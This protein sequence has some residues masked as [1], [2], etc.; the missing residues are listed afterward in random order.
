MD[1]YSVNVLNILK[2]IV[3]LKQRKFDR[4]AQL[5]ID[6]DPRDEPIEDATDELLNARLD[7]ALEERE[8]AMRKAQ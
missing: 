5:K 7:V 4:L 8:I 3:G 6:G 1:G 2:E